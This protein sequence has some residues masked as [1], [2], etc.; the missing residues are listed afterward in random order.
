MTDPQRIEIVTGHR[1]VRG[2]M[3]MGLALAGVAVF[4]IPLAFFEELE[5]FTV[6]VV[7]LFLFVGGCI[8]GAGHGLRIISLERAGYPLL[9]TAL[10][11]LAAVL[12]LEADEN[13]A[14]T[15]IGLL[16]FSLTLGLYGR[17]RDLGTLR[18]IRQTFAEEYPDDEPQ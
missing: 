13:A 1:A 18:K 14:R 16:V 10:S 4:F 12:F 8:S 11:A 15:F 2:L 3:Y 9:V 5:D 7:G 17:W 6:G